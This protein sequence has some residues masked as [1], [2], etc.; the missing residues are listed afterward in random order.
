MLTKVFYCEIKNA[1]E[2]IGRIDDKI[3]TQTRVKAG[4]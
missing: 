2:T 3:N 4:R 1:T